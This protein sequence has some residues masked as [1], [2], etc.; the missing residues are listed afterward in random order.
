MF[1]EI[2]GSTQ[3]VGNWP[4]VT[5][6]KKE[7]K[8][9][10]V[11]EDITIVDL[12]GIYSLS[13]YTMEEIIARNYIVEE[14]PDVIINIVDATNIERN[15]Y[16]TTQLIELGLPIVVALNMMDEIKK[17][18]DK[19][20]VNGLEKAFGVPIIPT[21]ASKGQ[22]VSQLM[23]KAIE[24]AQAGAA[25]QETKFTLKIF[26]DEI[27]NTI[28][29]IENLIVPFIKGTKYPARWVS[30]KLLEGDERVREKLAV[31]NEII[32]S[33]KVLRK[34]LEHKYDDDIEA[35]IADNRYRFI[36]GIIAKYV[37]K[38]SAK[39][40]LT[41][42]DK[43][44]KIVT[45]RVLAIPL[46]L[47]VMLIV[48]RITFGTV[49]TFLSDLLDGFINGTIAEAVTG[50]LES[51]GASEWLV[52]LIVNGIIAGVGGVLVFMPQIM[53]LFLFLS[54]LEDSGYMARAAFIMDRLLRKI[55]LSGKS[56]I[57][58][59]M[60]FGCTVPAVMAARTLQ[61]EKDRK[62]TIMLTPFMSCGARLP[63]YLVFA[64]AFFMQGQS[65]I[66]FSL[67]ILGVVVAILS[68]IILKTTLF[69]GD[70][71]PF[72][73]ELPPYRIPSVKGVAIHMW[74]RGKGFIKKAGTIIFA[75]SVIIWFAQSFS[76]SLRFV[77]SPDESILAAIGRFIAPI[78]VPLGFGDWK[79]SVSLVTGFAAKEVIVSTIG[80]LH[81]LGEVG[82]ESMELIS[83]LQNYYTPLKAYAFMAF[84]LLYL[85]CVAAFGAIKRELSSWKWT[86]FAVG[87]QT[88]IAWL[89]SFIIYQGGRLIGLA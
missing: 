62:L 43:I 5:V 7:G 89:I 83:V 2:T 57:P 59:L 24:L 25:S 53:I 35:I 9:R 8:A 84:T 4:G 58:M 68:G 61:S 50:L 70:S 42:S 44:D 56:F 34:E 55:G 37:K 15:L 52:E 85:P 77:E 36:T 82:E 78:F 49:G 29:K 1:N 81:G 10:K 14:M 38:N 27:E 41:I 31:T 23:Q 18:G 66:I 30:I 73:M 67:Y 46:F 79:T 74:D 86:L 20:D 21:S 60:G 16:L 33:V 45:N 54:I 75:A 71:A 88:A 40:D 64:S 32:D 19:I 28:E 3:Y 72:V 65:I 12:P 11:K 63:V 6:E 87:Y 39:G 26:D 51:A 76:F 17:R 22:G 69:K 13:P 80:I 48:F 47:A